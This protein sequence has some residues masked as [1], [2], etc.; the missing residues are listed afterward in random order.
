MTRHILS[1]TVVGF[2]VATVG[3]QGPKALTASQKADLFKKNRDVI[4]KV[5]TQTIDSSKSPNDPLKRA[6]TYYELL[7]LFSKQIQ[8]AGAANDGNRVKELTSHL[9]TLVEQGLAPTMQ[10]AKVQLEQGTGVEEFRKVRIDLLAQ[11]D[12]LLGLPVMDENPAAKT[13]LEGAKARL[14][15]IVIPEPK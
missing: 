13:S 10:R 6:K 1:F 14:N 2:L 5:V 12:A 3:A 11:L 4:E 9:N 7:F 8:S 15:G